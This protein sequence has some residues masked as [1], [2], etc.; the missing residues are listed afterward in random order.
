M[1][2]PFG[3]SVDRI[4]D[5]LKAAERGRDEVSLTG[6]GVDIEQAC[7]RLP[8]L[9]FDTVDFASD[10]PRAVVVADIEWLGRKDAVATIATLDTYIFWL[11]GHFTEDTITVTRLI[12]ETDINYDVVMGDE[13]HV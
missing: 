7:E 8:Y 11:I 1:K 10:E 2:P 13:D 6:I 5:L 12:G 9:R 3:Q 4:R